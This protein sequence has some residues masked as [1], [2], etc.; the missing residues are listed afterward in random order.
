MSSTP[1]AGIRPFQIQ[2]RAEDLDDLRDRLLSA[3][4]PVQPNGTGWERGVPLEYLRGLVDHWSNGFDWAAREQELN[5]FPQHMT[6]VEGQNI[7][8]VHARS[9]EPE[10]LPLVLLHGWPVSFVEF[11]QVIGPLSD[12]VGHGGEAR[13]AFHVVVPSHPGFGYSIPIQEPGWSTSRVAAVVVEIMHRLGYDRY[14]A[15]GGDVGAG[16]AAGLSPADPSGVVGVHVASDPRT[17][18]SFAM[19]A[20]DPALTPGL[21]DEERERVEKMKE[22]SADDMGYLQI[23]S[24]RPQTLAYGLTD[25]PVAQLAWIV[26]KFRAWTD[27][28]ADLPEDAV[29]LDLLLTNVALYWFTRTGAS[30]AHFLYDSMHAQDWGGEGSA[31]T[32]FAV[33]GRDSLSRRLMDPEKMIEHWS[34]FDRGGHFPAM[35]VPELLIEDIRSFFRPLR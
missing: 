34:E 15:H 9:P 2:V 10:A 11:S 14:G 28:T 35:E 16:V 25:S 23:Q 20:G 8:F 4:W 31:P 6:T 30:A 26:E 3:R 1:T 24:T 33:F 5:R 32:G 7:H 13:D 22:T 29:D 21:T 17:A 27:P 19:F 18:V 12:P